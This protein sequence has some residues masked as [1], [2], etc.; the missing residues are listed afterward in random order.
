MLNRES[1][2]VFGM[3]FEIKQGVINSSILRYVAIF[4][5]YFESGKE[6]FL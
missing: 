2:G 3:F 1:A 6:R 4:G 5:D